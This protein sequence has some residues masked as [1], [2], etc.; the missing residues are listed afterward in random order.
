M[1]HLCRPMA[2]IVL[3]VIIVPAAR[4]QEREPIGRFAADLRASL[5]RF[6]D[7]AATAS[8]LGVTTNDLPG[9]GLGLS[10]GLN[11][12]PFRLGKVTV[13]FGG[14]LLLSRGS[15]TPKPATEGGPVGPTIK[16]E[17]S[18]L[19]PQVS[20]N[21]GSRQGWSY[22]SAGIGRASFTTERE[23]APV[24]DATSNPRAI[25]YGGGARWFAKDH[26]A[27]TFDLRWYRVDAQAAAVGRPAY[28]GRR[29]MVLSA[30]ISV[31]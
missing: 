22:L 27:F 14:E 12:Y 4:A 10:A 16:T 2:A 30:G 11:V 13:G 15:R 29:I 5:P 20:F 3:A 17:F 23:A 1:T 19:S 26:L 25:N 24:A 9:R 8:V 18:V 6:P 7:D 21:F 28:T 31:K